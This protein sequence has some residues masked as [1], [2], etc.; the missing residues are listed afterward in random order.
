MHENTGKVELHLKSDVH[1]RSIDSRRPPQSKSS[2]GDLIQSR[3]LSVSQFLK[4]HGLFETRGFF[5]K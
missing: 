5:P 1:V 3:P 4:F 2:I